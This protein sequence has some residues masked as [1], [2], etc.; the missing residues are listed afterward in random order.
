MPTGAI[1]GVL[2]QP[3]SILRSAAPLGAGIALVCFAIAIIAGLIRD[4]YRVRLRAVEH[5][6]PEARADLIGSETHALGLSAKDL[7]EERRFRLI[8]EVLRQRAD[9][10]KHLFRFAILVACV[11]TLVAILGLFH[12]SNSKAQAGVIPLELAGKRDVRPDQ[13]EPLRV[14]ISTENSEGITRIIKMASLS[15]GMREPIVT[16][17]KY[18]KLHEA[19]RAKSG[20]DILM[21]DDPWVPELVKAGALAPLDENSVV[22]QYMEGHIAK[23]GDIAD[24]LFSDVFVESAKAA[25]VFQ[26]TVRMPSPWSGTLNF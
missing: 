15:L 2:T 6:P 7:S 11:L 24:Y 3:E 26:G 25:S 12:E 13:T 16:P 1:E 8:K 9:K 23:P 10:T 4:R 17:C 21:I 20:V 19:V 18:E 5:A 14:L 22:K